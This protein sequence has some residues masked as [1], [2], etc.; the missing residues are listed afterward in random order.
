MSNGESRPGA[1]EDRGETI[2]GEFVS[3]NYFDVLG[4]RP[5]LGRSFLPEED[6]I[7][8]AS[9]VVVLSD[10]LWRRRFHADPQIIGR[11]VQLNSVAFTVVG[12][13]PTTSRGSSESRGTTGC[14]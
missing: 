14:P 3:G 12:V 1:S 7:P 13:A 10:S 11:K 4:I 5:A 2:W 6:K 8:G 9:P